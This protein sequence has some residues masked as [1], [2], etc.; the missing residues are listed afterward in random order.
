MAIA[1]AFAAPARAQSLGDS[2]PRRREQEPAAQPKLTKAPQLLQTVDP[3][4]PA[5]ALAGKLSADV[6]MFVDIDATG[7]VSR[8]V[9]TKPA[10][11]GFDE[12]AQ[13]AVMKYL[14][15][16]AE[17]DGKPGAIRIEYTLHFVPKV[18][19]VATDVDG[20][21]DG[22]PDVDGGPMNVTD[23]GTPDAQPAPPPPPPPP[24]ALVVARG[25]LR[26][27]GRRDPIR[28]AEVTVI[29]RPANAPEKPGVL[30]ATTDEEGRFEIKGQPGV[31]L[32]VIIADPQHD[33]CIRDL[34]AS[35]VSAESP[36]EIECLV[37]K[38]AG[39]TYETTVRAPPPAQA[40]TRYTLAKSE[41]TTVPG[42]FG[43]PL[44]VIQNLPGVARP[45][46]GL[47]LLVI[48]GA[49]PDDSGIYVEGQKIPILYHF[50]VGPSVLTPRLI[51]HIDFYPG[52]FGVKYGRVTAGIVDVG[53]TTDATP[54]LHGEADINL[55]D[56][57]AYVEGPLA[58]GWTGSVS[59]RRSYYDL[60]LPLVLPSS[61][62]TVSPVYW[63]YQAGV[64]RDFAGG[65]LAFFAFGS[66]DSLEII[67]KSPSTGN[68]S[69]GTS[70]GFHKVFAVWSAA[71]HGWVNRLSPAYGYEK[72]TFG[73]GEVGI[74]QSQ[75]E[76]SLRDELS[77]QLHK[78]LIWRV[79]LDV[80]Q[81]FDNLYVNLPLAQNT[82]LYGD[83]M[84][85]PQQTTIPL[86][87]FGSALYTDATYEPGGGVTLTPGLRGDYFRY[88]GR[89]R[90]TWDP[91][92]VARWKIN[93]KL[94]LKGG[95]G[96]FH[97]M[98]QPQLLNAQYGN[99]SLPPIWADQ[100]SV[101]FVRNLT[102]KL[103]LD[104]TFYYVS[105]HNEPVSVSGGFTPDGRARSYGMEVI[106]KHDFTE[107][108][109]GWVAYTL[110][111]SEQTVYSVNGASL[112]NGGD[113]ALQ[114]P[115]ATSKV[116]WYP[117]DFDQTHNLNMIASYNWGK[118]RLGGRFRLVTGTPTTPVLEGTYDA[119]MG[120]YACPNGPTNSARKPT[121][122]QLDGRL[123][124]KW[125]FNAW[126]L[127]AYLDVQNIYNA[128][129]PELTVPDYRCRTS[130]QVQGIPFLPTF[131]VRGMF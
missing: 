64:H 90:F 98:Q 1:L 107:R 127:G 87:T 18:V 100:Y 69:L 109:Y 88:V 104:T 57:S 62:T 50:L 15:S 82:R 91:R 27:K 43:D 95:V 40:V 120:T 11:H 102:D 94:A 9:I 86:G 65:R 67:S 12:A 8:V 22:A 44:R 36:A 59:A 54:H 74:N 16:P 131:G 19:P 41:L 39:A 108:F 116:T 51:D 20:G 75:H 10:G 42:T 26:A 121:F 112:G 122:N 31:S 48:R 81:T 125:T 24:P 126:E 128:K 84:L 2:M 3:E 105:R 61:S 68:L 5:D 92:V 129:N 7:H 76:L 37:A 106:L 14:F 113:G 117:T 118:W 29:E 30:A 17:I 49:S 111:R 110:S 93:D 55:L 53:I 71:A 123:E 99:P 38:R 79:G 45:P 72:L 89:D 114:N 47:G 115:N 35:K 63:D 103:T 60:L 33:P 70:T 46:F 101:G 73:A 13:A 78:K 119:D 130:L 4:Y 23:G 56:S 124:R 32:R 77:R 83:Q 58:K 66:N 21:V 34:D 28:D 80:D 52:N 96:I 6:T 85:T 25:R 97:Q